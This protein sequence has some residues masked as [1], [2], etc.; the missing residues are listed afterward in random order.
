[1][2]WAYIAVDS[3]GQDYFAEALVPDID[4]VRLGSPAK[5]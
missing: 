5:S 3:Q 1:V 4:P 2:K